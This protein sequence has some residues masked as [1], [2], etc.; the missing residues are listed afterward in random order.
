MKQLSLYAPPFPASSRRWFGVDLLPEPRPGELR[1]G[2]FNWSV[3]FLSCL[4]CSVL[5]VAM[6]LLYFIPLRYLVLIWGV[7][8]F[9]KKLRNPYTIDNNEILNF[10]KRVPTDVQKVQYSALRAPT[11]QI[12]PRRKK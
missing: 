11:S 8:K 5:F 9:T 7:N 4:A 10:L 1:E 6:L 12:P 3:P 2:M